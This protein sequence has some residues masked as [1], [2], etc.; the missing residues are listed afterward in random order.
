MGSG[1]QTEPRR[2]PGGAAG[3]QF[4]K[5]DGDGDGHVDVA[6]IHSEIL[7]M[8]HSDESVSLYNG[9]NITK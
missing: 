1:Y 2:S 5:L 4:D 8:G 3:G 7:T 9:K 6:D